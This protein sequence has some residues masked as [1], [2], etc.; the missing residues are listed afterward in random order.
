MS[1]IRLI[2]L[3]LFLVC[4]GGV[5]VLFA[6][7]NSAEVQLDLI[8]TT[9]GPLPISLLLVSVFVL[10]IL[11]GVVFSRLY[12]FAHKFGRRNKK[13]NTAEMVTVKP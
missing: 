4:V 5:G 12:S 10:G 9:V 11:V 2:L 6:W 8:F 1:K 3:I 7:V 13:E